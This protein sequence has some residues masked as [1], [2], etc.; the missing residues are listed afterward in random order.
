MSLPQDYT[1]RPHSYL[2][3]ADGSSGTQGTGSIVN[4]PTLGA[5]TVTATLSQVS[6]TEVPSVP[7]ASGALPGSGSFIKV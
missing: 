1:V 6:G 3:R 7:N 4:Y 2:W 5:G